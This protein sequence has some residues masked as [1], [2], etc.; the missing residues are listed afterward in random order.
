LAELRVHRSA[1]LG[2]ITLAGALAYVGADL[3]GIAVVDLAEPAAPK[4]LRPGDRKMKITFP[5]MELDKPW[6]GSE[7]TPQGQ[8]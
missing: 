3:I 2:R 5:E 4:A 8:R 1:L 6:S 7:A